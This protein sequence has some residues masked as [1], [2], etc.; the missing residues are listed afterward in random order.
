ME[1]YVKRKKNL[2]GKL[3]KWIMEWKRDHIIGWKKTILE[4]LK[5]ISFMVREHFIIKEIKFIKG[6][7][8]NQNFLVLDIFFNLLCVKFLKE[9]SRI[10]KNGFGTE[11]DR[12][13]N[14]IF[15]GEF[16]NNKKMVMDTNLLIIFRHLFL[17]KNNKKTNPYTEIPKNL[18]LLQSI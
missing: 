12:N 15:E 1:F 8:I 9:N 14:K 3:G 5:I 10:I 11:F 4:N 6:S 13:G 16:K 18:H 2:F 17:W 7:L